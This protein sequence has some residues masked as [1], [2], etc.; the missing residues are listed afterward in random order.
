MQPHSP[1]LPTDDSAT[2]TAK[3]WKKPTL[4]VLLVAAVLAALVAFLMPKKQVE[5]R[6]ASPST[7]HR[8]SSPG[9]NSPTSK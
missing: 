2:P 5:G 8:S 4:Y 7:A 1:Q 6:N 3:H 9:F